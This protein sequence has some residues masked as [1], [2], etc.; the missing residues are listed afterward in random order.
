[1]SNDMRY[2]KYRQRPLRVGRRTILAEG[3]L[4]STYSMQAEWVRR[5]LSFKGPELQAERC[6]SDDG[7]LEVSLTST[8]PGRLWLSY[9]MTRIRKKMKN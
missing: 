6:R 1:M 2:S 7:L 9:L 8:S 3:L 4:L 5:Y